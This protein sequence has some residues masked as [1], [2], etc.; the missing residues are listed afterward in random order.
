MYCLFVHSVFLQDYASNHSLTVMWEQLPGSSGLHITLFPSFCHLTWSGEFS[1]EG[2]VLSDCSLVPWLCRRNYYFWCLY[3]S[4]RLFSVNTCFLLI[5]LSIKVFRKF[6]PYIIHLHTV[7]KLVTQIALCTEKE[8]HNTSAMW[9][10][11]T[12]TRFSKSHSNVTYYNM[13]TGKRT[14]VPPHS[15]CLVLLWMIRI[16]ILQ[17]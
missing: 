12:S 4:D 13:I 2:D 1:S 3:Q 10:R 6:K 14:P 5:L 7:L 11:Q 8:S 9:T 15:P 17:L 16:T